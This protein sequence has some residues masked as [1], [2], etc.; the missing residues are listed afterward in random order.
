MP[1]LLVLDIVGLSLALTLSAALLLLVSSAGLRKGLNLTFVLFAASES[2]WAACFLLLRLC[3]WLKTGDT[4]LLMNLSVVFFAL[5]GIF[6][7][8]FSARYMRIRH[9][10]PQVVAYGALA[11]LVIH[12]VPLFTGRIVDSPSMGAAGGIIYHFTPWGYAT[13][14]AAAASILVSLVILYTRRRRE[15]DPYIAAG[16]TLLFVGCLTSGIFFPQ[17][18]LLPL[19][20]AAGMGIMG[21]GIMRWQLFNPLHDLTTDLRERAHRQELIAKISRRTATLLDL[22][23]LFHQAVT[24]I[25]ETFDYFAV[26]VFLV[27]GDDLVLR[28]STHPSAPAKTDIYR[29]KVG[30][31]GI[32]GWVAA[33]GAPLLVGRRAQGTPVRGDPSPRH[34]ALGARRAD[35]PQRQGDRR[36]GRTERAPGRVR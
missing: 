2:G 19:T 7:L 34:D 28:A 25:Q 4:A 20:S 5:V 24:L 13:G 15:S 18:S 23:E 27:D 26:A 29:L 3:L 16:A 35:L 6:L 10:W 22:D 8:F 14:V 17:L 33:T 9:V 32:C 31:E 30:V 12:L 21:W 1:P 11:A 36:A